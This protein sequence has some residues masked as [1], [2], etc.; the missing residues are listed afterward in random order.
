MMMMGITVEEPDIKSECNT[1][2]YRIN[3][4]ELANYNWLI[5]WMNKL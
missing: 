5:E 2:L 3:K 1:T 4:N